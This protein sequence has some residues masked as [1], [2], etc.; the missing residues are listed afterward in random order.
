MIVTDIHVSAVIESE[1]RREGSVLCVGFPRYPAC[2][3]KLLA[4]KKIEGKQTVLLEASGPMNR[5]LRML[6][7][8]AAVGIR[9]KDNV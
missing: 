6:S 7:V 4:G 1:D 9:S 5:M 8:A 3:A 2:I